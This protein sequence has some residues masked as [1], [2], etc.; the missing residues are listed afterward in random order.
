M[1]TIYMSFED[2]PWK[3]VSSVCEDIPFVQERTSFIISMGQG[4]FLIPNEILGVLRIFNIEPQYIHRDILFIEPFLNGADIVRANVIPPTLV[5]SQ[6]PVSWE[7][8]CSRQF[9][10]L[11]EYVF[12]RRPRKKED[13]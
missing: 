12:R 9:G 5:I 1:T 7:Y 4:I 3:D 10:I 13:I 8:R 6:S 11:S 2:E